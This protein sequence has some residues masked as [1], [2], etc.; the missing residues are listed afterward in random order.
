MANISVDLDTIITAESKLTEAQ[1]DLESLFTKINTAF[2]AIDSN[3]SG[4]LKVSAQTDKQHAN[5]ALTAVK[6]DIIAVVDS[7][8]KIKANARNIKYGKYNGGEN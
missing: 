7:F 3:W 6:N 5:D 4:P 2:D 8:T 1:Q